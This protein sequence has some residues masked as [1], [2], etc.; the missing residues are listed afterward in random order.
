M[1][2]MPVRSTRN[3]GPRPSPS[4]TYEATKA[5]TAIALLHSLPAIVTAYTCTPGTRLIESAAHARHRRLRRLRPPLAARSEVARDRARGAVRQRDA[6]GRGL[7][8]GHDVAR[9]RGGARRPAGGAGAAAFLCG[10]D[11]RDSPVLAEPVASASATA[12][13]LERWRLPGEPAS[14]QWEERFGEHVYV[15]LGESAVTE[16]LKR[17]GVTA[18]SINHWV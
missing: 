15:P 7:R 8:R 16:A 3:G 1:I 6:V 17:A 12:E 4:P 5:A 14:R 10:D 9:R 18:P 2:A 13:F 11:S